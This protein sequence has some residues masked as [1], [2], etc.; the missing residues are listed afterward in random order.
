MVTFVVQ[1]CSNDAE[2]LESVGV[3]P[4]LPVPRYWLPFTESLEP[5]TDLL[6][7]RAVGDL[8]EFD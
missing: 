5:S 6:I 1:M 2:V 4:Q 7:R 8:S 3:Y